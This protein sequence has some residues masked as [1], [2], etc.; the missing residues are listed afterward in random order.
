RVRTIGTQLAHQA[1]YSK[2]VVYAFQ[3]LKDPSPNA[4]SLPDGHV[5]VTTGLMTL[6]GSNDDQL[7][8]V[9]GHEIGHLAEEHAISTTERVMTKDLGV[10][11]FEQIFGKKLGKLGGAATELAGDY[12]VAQHS[13]DQEVDADRY[14]I[15]LAFKC[16]YDP[17]A[18]IGLLTKL[19]ARESDPGP[20]KYFQSHPLSRE[21][22]EQA[23]EF[24]AQTDNGRFL[25]QHY[26]NPKPPLSAF[27]FKYPV[28]SGT[29]LGHEDDFPPGHAYGLRAHEGKKGKDKDKDKDDDDRDRD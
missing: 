11:L 24:L 4:F 27:T 17:S 16:G 23:R 8:A 19:S 25:N 29:K 9:L 2:G 15:A 6:V 26:F 18:T 14:G 21:R 28:Y 22:I 1:R 13:Q 3:V 10:G 5:Y 12:V 7:A 20:F